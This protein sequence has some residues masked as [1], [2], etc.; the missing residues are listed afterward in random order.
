MGEEET[1]EKIIFQHLKH[2]GMA[3]VFEVFTWLF[4]AVLFA[5]EL[6]TASVVL[7]VTTFVPKETKGK[8]GVKGKDGAKG[9]GGEGEGGEAEGKEE[10]GANSSPV[11]K[12]QLV[13]GRWGD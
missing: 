3:Y 7:L 12:Q 10:G 4:N 9:K 5:Y 11:V 6:L 2:P 13:G 8:D 1:K